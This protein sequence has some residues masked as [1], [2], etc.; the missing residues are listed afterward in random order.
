MNNLV[1]KIVD[2]VGSGSYIDVQGIWYGDDGSS[3]EFTASGIDFSQGP[4]A[5]WEAMKAAFAA[6]AN[7]KTEPPSE[8]TAANVLMR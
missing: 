8:L 1:V 2:M 5:T 6:E 4:T 3:G 7:T